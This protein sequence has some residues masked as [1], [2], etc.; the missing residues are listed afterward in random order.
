MLGLFQQVTLYEKKEEYSYVILGP[1]T[2]QPDPFDKVA[3][4][5]S[6]T[7]TLTESDIICESK[8]GSIG[9]EGLYL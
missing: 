7:L 2:Y 6:G 5:T 1:L 3:T 8:G 4:I 9:A